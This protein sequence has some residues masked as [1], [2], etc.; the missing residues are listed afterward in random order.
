M[1]FEKFFP[2]SRSDYGEGIMVQEYAG[3]WYL[4]DARKPPKGDG[5]V[6]KSYG[7][8]TRKQNGKTITVDDNEGNPRSFP[9]SVCIGYDVEQAAG[10]LKAVL[11]QLPTGP[12]ADTDDA[13]F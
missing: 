5:T 10:F 4:V 11:S 12:P 2:N 6:Y 8:K 13:P 3:K 9:W 7:Y 1:A